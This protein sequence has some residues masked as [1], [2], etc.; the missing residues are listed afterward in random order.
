MNPNMMGDVENGSVA[1]PMSGSGVGHPDHYTIGDDDDST[2]QPPPSEMGHPTI[3]VDMDAHHNDDVEGAVHDQLPSPEEYKAKMSSG[4]ATPM[5]GGTRSTNG[6]PE[7]DD[8]NN[9]HD[10]LPSVDEYK[11]SRSFRESPP[12]KSRAGLYT[13]LFLLLVT[14]IATA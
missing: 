10:Q 13:F 9:V 6:T 5:S 14:V 3:D 11:A 2:L 7:D 8:D 4:F 1:S 12:T